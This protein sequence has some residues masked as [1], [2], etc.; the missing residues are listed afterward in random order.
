MRSI[1]AQ[2]GGELLAATRGEGGGGDAGNVGWKVAI[3]DGTAETGLGTVATSE[4][5]ADG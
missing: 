1:A 2:Q 4:A 3:G 5:T